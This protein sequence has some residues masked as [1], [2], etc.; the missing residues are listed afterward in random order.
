MMV[1]P[2]LTLTIVRHGDTFAPGEPARRIG[3]AT[4]LPLVA[5]G[6]A[7]AR[8]L[9]RSFAAEGLVF[10][11][12]LSSP[13]RRTQATVALILAVLPALPPIE[14]C[15]WLAE[16]DHGPD[17]NRTEDEVRA[18]IGEAALADWNEALIAPPGWT[19][20]APTRLAAWRALLST[21]TGHLL[22]V[23][24][25]GAA[26]FALAAD[27]SLT[28]Q[29]ASLPSTKLRTGAWGRI[30]AERGQCTIEAWD[31]RPEPSALRGAAARGA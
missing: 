6:E 11:R 24:S 27:E 10:D 29:A 20:D 28:E 15:S 30:A 25:A 12:V 2:S 26:R 1:R 19:V 8:A 13:L 9:G 17:E 4:D 3:A 5:S 31:R 18:R 7:Q 21:A 23:T 16:I 22:L 14:R